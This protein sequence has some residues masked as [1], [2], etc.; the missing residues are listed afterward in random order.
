MTYNWLTDLP[1][2]LTRWGVD[3]YGY[4]NYQTHAY[5]PP[6]E[7]N[8]TPVGLMIHHTAST[9]WYPVHKLVDSCNLYIDPAGQ[10][11]L[12]SL[13][14]QR[15]S[16]LGDPNA[17]YR[18]QHMH[19]PQRPLDFTASDRINGNQWFVDI[20][21]G[22]PGD[23]SPIP[24]QQRDALLL[25]SAAVCDVLNLD[26]A[27]Q[28]IGHKEWTRRKI[29][30]R[31]SYRFNIDEMGMIRDDIGEVLKGELMPRVLFEGMIDALFAADG[32]F[33]GDPQ[34]WKTLI[35]DP[36]NSEWDDFWAAFTRMVS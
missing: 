34:Y 20:E 19:P 24:T 18:V 11:V 27:T 1:S 14:R 31:W 6:D 3:W 26:A 9:A 7:G 2:A 13:G 17:L 28:V 36:T 10:A 25:V 12:Y 32:E 5:T 35:D 22:H 33:Q 29:D 23:G 4:G 16:G 30:P 8:Y 21:V 15:D